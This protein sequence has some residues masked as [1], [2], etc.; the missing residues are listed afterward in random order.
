[1]LPCSPNNT[2]TLPVNESSS[3]Y[4]TRSVCL[5]IS[6]RQGRLTMSQTGSQS[7]EDEIQA[8]WVELDGCTTAVASRR[9]S[10]IGP[11]GT[12]SSLLQGELERILLEAQLECE[13]STHAD[14]S[15]NTSQASPQKTT[16]PQVASEENSVTECILQP[17]DWHQCRRCSS[18]EWVWQWSSRPE[19]Q[20]PKK[21]MFQQPKRSC[22]LGVGKSGA[23]KWGFFSSE[24]FLLFIPSLVTSHLLTL[25]V[26]IYL[27]KRLATSSTSPL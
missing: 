3:R 17:E 26:G 7:T 13:R 22:S 6:L 8:S 25:A 4:R 10:V 20:P 18:A 21:L 23:M 5:R 16:T 11:Q 14:G 9:D 12:T 19:N 15:E 1:M 2:D 24:V 27:G